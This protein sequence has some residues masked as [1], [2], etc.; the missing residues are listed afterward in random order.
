MSIKKLNYLNDIIFSWENN[1]F[2]QDKTFIS[3]EKVYN[4]FNGFYE[5]NSKEY[6]ENLKWATSTFNILFKDITSEALANQYFNWPFKPDYDLLEVDINI[7]DD[8]LFSRYYQNLQKIYD[9]LSSNS[10]ININE[11][12]TENKNT[13]LF[14]G[15]KFH[16][17]IK[18]TGNKILYW[19]QS[20]CMPWL[21]I[22]GFD[23]LKGTARASVRINGIQKTIKKYLEYMENQVFSNNDSVIGEK[24]HIINSQINDESFKFNN[25]KTLG[26]ALISNLGMPISIKAMK[27]S[28]YEYSMYLLSLPINGDAFWVGNNGLNLFANR[29]SAI[30][31]QYHPWYYIIPF[32]PWI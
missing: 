3:K 14:D 18:N 12:I 30:T 26:Q 20:D 16:N 6:I 7:S 19:P 15:L 28:Q 24:I 8:S 23:V 31:W 29:D 25:F 17:Y 10:L 9:E 1:S 22:A 21:Y 27:I 13:E 2:P 32:V 11:S 5:R 4:S